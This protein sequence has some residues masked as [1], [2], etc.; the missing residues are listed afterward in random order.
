MTGYNLALIP[1]IGMTIF[2]LV[3]AVIIIHDNRKKK[4]HR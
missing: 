1:L 3:L 4:Q 2:A